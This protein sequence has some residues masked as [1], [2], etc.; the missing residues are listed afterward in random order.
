[1]CLSP[2]RGAEDVGI[3]KRRVSSPLSETRGMREVS[4]ACDRDGVAEAEAAYVARRITFWLWR[5][6]IE[7]RRGRY[8]EIE[9]G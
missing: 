2:G 4:A 7:S 6:F 5:V 9:S 8:K 1:M 3:R